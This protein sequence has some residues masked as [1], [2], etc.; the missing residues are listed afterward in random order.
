MASPEHVATPIDR[1]LKRAALLAVTLLALA[2]TFWFLSMTFR[3][4]DKTF[5]FRRIQDSEVLAVVPPGY[6]IAQSGPE[7][8]D[9]NYV[10]AHM[11]DSQDD[12]VV[13]LL[14]WA[15]QQHSQ[16]PP[17][18]HS[19]MIKLL[20]FGHEADKWYEYAR[21][22]LGDHTNIRFSYKLIAL[23]GDRADKLIVFPFFYAIADLGYDQAGNPIGA[24]PDAEMHQ[25]AAI[26]KLQ[27]SD[28]VDM[29]RYGHGAP[30]FG[31]VTQDGR[32]D[33]MMVG[34]DGSLLFAE[35]VKP[36]TA[37]WR[38]CYRLRYT[39]FFFK[40]R[41]AAFLSRNG[42]F[43]PT[44]RFTTQS[45]YTGDPAHQECSFLIFAGSALVEEKGI[46]P[47]FLAK[48]TDPDIVAAREK[49]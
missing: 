33:S 25:S 15:K 23:E 46:P 44:D 22:S 4:T 24:K 29:I 9:I 34:P 2:A 40:K 7:K 21:T 11:E 37:S 3:R 45:A 1:I 39:R 17:V 18:E 19:V 38:G 36:P 41:E 14:E 27:G 47:S 6:R 42:A 35:F 49:H 10:I 12:V 13:V 8:N 20:K 16:M 26:L 28:L 32:A 31:N 43:V 30:T 48:P 5:P